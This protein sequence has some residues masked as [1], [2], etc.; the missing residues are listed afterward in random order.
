MS[1]LRGEEGMVGRFRF[2][3]LVQ[4]ALLASPSRH[5]PEKREN[6]ERR[7]GPEKVGSTG[8]G[9]LLYTVTPR[10]LYYETSRKDLREN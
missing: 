1:V 3:G 7:K 4:R 9:T 5:H 10:A 6:P 8:L 2:R